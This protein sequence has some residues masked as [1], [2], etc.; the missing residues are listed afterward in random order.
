MPESAIP[1]ACSRAVGLA[2]GVALDALV[3]DPQRHHPVAWFGSW[4]GFVERHTYRDSRPAGAWHVAATVVPVVGLAVV[5]ERLSR[6]HP[7]AHAAATAV[8]TWAV[9]GATSL[10]RE[11]NLMADRLDAD[12]LDGARARLGNLCGR[13][14]AGL[15]EPELARAAVES[16]AENTADAAV[17]SLAWGA[18]AGIPGLVAHRCL[19]TLDAM[20][21]HRNDRYARF[22]TAAARLDDAADWVPARVTGALACALAPTVGG[23]AARAWRVM[24]RDG[25]RHP[26]PNGGWCE[27][28]WA[29]ALD[30]Q[31][32][33]T[34]VYFTRSE[35][36]ALLGDGP[37]PKAAQL[38]K[39][40]SLV[41]RATTAA[42]ALAVGALLL[43]RKRTR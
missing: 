1:T 30:V 2:A 8:A 11:G 26:S 38:R 21:G 3:G 29:G 24:R 25:A 18:V 17:A 5:A 14:P 16:M 4:A 10:A 28:A 23:S 35:E 31:L 27:S 42:T 43:L 32:G 15:D 34:N 7:V 12:D 20:V 40:A 22:G 37:R 19:N 33:G 9:V 36:R 6:R 39:A 41:T 13:D